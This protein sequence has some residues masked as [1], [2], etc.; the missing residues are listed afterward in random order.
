MKKRKCVFEE[1]T[2]NFGLPT[3]QPSDSESEE[4]EATTKHEKKELAQVKMYSSAL[5]LEFLFTS[6]PHYCAVKAI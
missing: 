4:P 5:V 3:P 2:N 6:G 1:M